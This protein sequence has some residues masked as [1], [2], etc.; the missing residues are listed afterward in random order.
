MSASTDPLRFADFHCPRCKYDL[1]GLERNICPEC[2][3]E[4]TTTQRKRDYT[5]LWNAFSFVAAVIAVALGLLVAVSSID[6]AMRYASERSAG[7]G[8]VRLAAIQTVTFNL[9]IPL[10][11]VLIMHRLARRHRTSRVIARLARTAA[12]AAWT[13]STLFIW[14]ITDPLAF[15]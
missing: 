14:F 12:L 5:L 7:C 13:A 1:R 3:Q 10:A 9:P 11:G 8:S 2:G 6:A 15:V 4:F